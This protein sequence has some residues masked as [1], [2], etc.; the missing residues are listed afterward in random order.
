MTSMPKLVLVTNYRAE[1][2]ALD[3]TLL[4]TQLS[5]N[6]CFAHF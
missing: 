6:F 1:N 5:C 2:V 4:T 3:K